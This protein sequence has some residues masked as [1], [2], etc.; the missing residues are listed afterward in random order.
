MT[1][2]GEVERNLYQAPATEGFAPLDAAMELPEE[3][4]SYE[5]QRIVAE[6]AARASFDEV[7]ELVKKQSGADVPKRQVEQLA[8]RASGDF[9]EF[10]R[11]RLSSPDDTTHL[12]VLSFD[13][14]GIAT[15][16]RDLRK[17]TRKAAETTPRRLET[18]LAK[19]RS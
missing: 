11:D 13:A 16:H 1:E 8:I 18:R 17:V 3:K 10:Y 4:Y 14:K 6:E 7:V 12:L 5:V 2:F 15:L 19:G 9:D